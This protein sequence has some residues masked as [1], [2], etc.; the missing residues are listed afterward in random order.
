MMASIAAK[1]LAFRLS[2]YKGFGW[3]GA[4]VL[5]LREAAGE[6]SRRSE[7]LRSEV[8]KRLAAVQAG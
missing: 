5:D 8:S 6:W 2:R 4:H 3:V 7:M 1:Q